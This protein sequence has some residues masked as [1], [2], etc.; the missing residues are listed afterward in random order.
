MYFEKKRG[1]L[2]RR[3]HPCPMPSLTQAVLTAKLQ[4][5]LSEEVSAEFAE[6]VNLPHV[7]FARLK[8]AG[9]TKQKK[10]CSKNSFACGYSCQP[11][12]TKS[13]K[14]TQC[15]SPLPDQAK[16][17]AEALAKQIKTENNKGVDVKDSKGYS[18]ES[19]GKSQGVTGMQ[20]QELPKLEGSEKQ[21][22]WAE[23]LR[24]DRLD[25]VSELLGEVNWFDKEKSAQ[26]LD[27]LGQVKS[28]KFWID[29]R[30]Y[31][32]STGMVFWAATNLKIQ[33]WETESAT[34]QDYKKTNGV[35]DNNARAEIFGMKFKTP[36]TIDLAKKIWLTVD[37]DTGRV[38]P[39]SGKQPES[40]DSNYVSSLSRHM[41]DGWAANDPKFFAVKYSSGK[42]T[43]YPVVTP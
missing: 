22:A 29:N 11:R 34:I 39:S 26:I 32:G 16:T 14:E 36:L 1:S 37:L 40:T 17:Y 15:R 35:L 6:S 25:K 30:D 24:K 21:V 18:K 33:P 5:F 28:S 23:K 7:D 42:F 8:M 27:Y 3:D 9:N 4:R 10:N 13:G 41:P 19:S 38:K 43:V 2:R 20:V 12:F 31:T